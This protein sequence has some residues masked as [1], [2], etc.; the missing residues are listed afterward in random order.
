[1]RKIL[2]GILIVS[3]A[4]VGV[5]SSVMAYGGYGMKQSTAAPQR[6]TGY[7]AVELTESQIDSISELR[8]EFYTETEELRDQLRNL[9]WDS[10]DLYVKGASNAEIGA[11]EDEIEVIVEQLAEMREEHQQKIEALLTEEQLEVIENNR[12]NF[13]QRFSGRDYGRFDGKYGSRGNYGPGMRSRNFGPGSNNN[14]GPGMMG[15]GFNNFDGN[16]GYGM[17]PGFCY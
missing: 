1:M 4:L 14:Y 11:L 15:R 8:E 10:R 3:L 2:V 12:A 9:R 7:Q 16:S 17:G 6:G 5:G 13:E